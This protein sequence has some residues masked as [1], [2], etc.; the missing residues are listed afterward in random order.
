MKYVKVG[1]CKNLEKLIRFNHS[2]YLLL[3][4][5]EFNVSK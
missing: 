1:V 2:Y 5:R 3:I 4:K